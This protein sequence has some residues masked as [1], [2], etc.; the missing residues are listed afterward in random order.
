MQLTDKEA[1]N[2]TMSRQNLSRPYNSTLPALTTVFQG[3][4]TPSTNDSHTPTDVQHN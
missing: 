4:N 1:H 2:N 3:P